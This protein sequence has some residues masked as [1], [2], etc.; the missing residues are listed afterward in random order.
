[1][2]KKNIQIYFVMTILILSVSGMAQNRAFAATSPDLGT[3]SDF[4]VLAKSTITNSGNTTITGDLG[5]STGT[6]ISGFFGTTANEGPGTVNGTIYQTNATAVTA[7]SDATSAYNELNLNACTNQSPWPVNVGER[8]MANLTLTPGVYCS[9]T[10][11]TLNLAA[12]GVLT[13]NGSGVYI[14]KAGSS[15]TT[16]ENSTVVLINGATADDIFWTNVASATL[17]KPGVGEESTEFK[18]TVIAQSSISVTG[19][20]ADTTLD[21]EG[22]LFALTGAV[23]FAS[24]TT[25]TVPTSEEGGGG[26]GG[27]GDGGSGSDSNGGSSKEWATKPTFGIS[28]QTNK[29]FV[30]D[31]FGYNVF[32]KTI[33]DNFHTGFSMVNIPTDTSYPLYA[34]GYFANQLK[35]QEFCFGIPETGKGY[36]AESCIEVHFDS[37]SGDDR[38][39]TDVQVIQDSNVIDDVSVQHEM[40]SCNTS[41]TAKV[42][43]KTMITIAFAEPLQHSV[44]MIKGIDWKGKSTETYL[45]EGFNVNGKQ[46]TDLPTAMIPGPT[47]YEGLIQVTQSEKYS[48]IWVSDDERMFERNSSGSFNQIKQ[49]HERHQDTGDMKN[50]THSAFAEWKDQQAIKAKNIWDSS[51]YVSTLAPSFA[52]DYPVE[53]SRTAFLNAHSMLEFARGQ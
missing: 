13:L 34:K 47:K 52:Y 6:I 51:K 20:A 12:D 22:R 38:K 5:L 35:T 31:G 53:D 45:N 44:M 14:F 49:T 7:I 43:D 16:V 42:C 2:I 1:M 25:V 37:G 19:N 39:I 8:Q 23:T 36:L 48:N 3:S 29:Q 10:D 9:D 24:I 21:I 18:G 30:T 46:L 50:R 15:L 40:A 33:T 28:Y 17:A 26:G 27:G 11:S 32:A 4:A 41:D